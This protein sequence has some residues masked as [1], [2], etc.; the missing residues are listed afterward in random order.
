MRQPNHQQLLA[1]GTR[2]N[3]WMIDAPLSVGPFAVVYEGH[4]LHVDEPVIVKEY[5]PAA[6]ARRLDGRLALLDVPN[7]ADQH[8]AALERFIVQ[9]RLL[10]GLC[11]NK[12]PAHLASVQGVTKANPTAYL[13]M[14]RAA[15]EPL[16][17]STRLDA[18]AVEALIRRIG[19]GLA[20]AHEAGVV[21]GHIVPENILIDADGHPTL[22]G[23]G[24]V[25]FETAEDAGLTPFTPP[26]A[27]L[28]QYVA[29][30]RQGPW[31]DIYALGI[32]AYQAL[33]GLTPPEVIG[34]TGSPRNR[35]L[36]AR[37][38]PDVRPALLAAI[39]AAV[40]IAPQARPQSILEWL[41]LLDRDQSAAA[42]APPEPAVAAAPAEPTAPAAEKIEAL[43]PPLQSA[44]AIPAEVRLPAIIP[45]RRVPAR[46]DLGRLAKGRLAVLARRAHRHP[47]PIAAVAAVLATAVASLL[48]IPTDPVGNAPADMRAEAIRPVAVPDGALASTLEDA[49]GRHAVIVRH[50]DA[51]ANRV[52]ED[53]GALRRL[54]RGMP[55]VAATSLLARADASQAAVDAALAQLNE[56]T[57]ALASASDKAAIA[58]LLET[59]TAA[60]GAI[61]REQRTALQ[62]RGDAD[63][64]AQAA[65]AGA[66]AARR[67][68]QRVALERAL[69]EARE[70]QVQA[71]AAIGAASP[72]R[73]RL[74]EAERTIDRQAKLAADA[75]ARHSALQRARRSVDAAKKQLSKLLAEAKAPAA[76]PLRVESAAPPDPAVARFAK[77]AH[78][79]YDDVN[80]EYQTLS[81]RIERAYRQRPSGDP[82]VT[83]AYAAA[84]EVYRGLL[85]LAPRRDAVIAAP[86]AAEAE[87]RLVDLKAALKP[88]DRRL[89]GARRGLQP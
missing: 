79:A 33:T 34:R 38:W 53:L 4:A 84:S 80:R 5:F 64:A 55:A 30:Y 37:D 57:A 44:W 76:V 31:T 10:R 48:L 47:R 63:Q 70:L 49:R 29:A 61:D 66:D 78:R 41:A 60:G 69:T 43:L 81:S 20:L 83:A 88:L 21:H 2:L 45:S 46:R 82:A 15:G 9:A 72:L 52:A 54:T 56:T 36:V 22:I 86:T 32:I 51:Q 40:Q 3:G 17:G 59:A 28:E 18:E 16:G 42:T 11:Q 89:D 77:Q 12:K 87:H 85:D 26:Y 13:V 75:D 58:R 19:S 62:L 35:K 24:S 7:A 1:P 25:P 6:V 68:V 71:G 73:P 8:A 14:S 50:A 74:A 39:D 23:F 27:A 67:D 65:Q